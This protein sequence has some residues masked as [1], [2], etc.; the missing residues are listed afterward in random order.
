MVQRIGQVVIA[1]GLAGG[2]L[3]VAEDQEGLAPPHPL[4]GDEPLDVIPRI[5]RP[6]VRAMTLATAVGIDDVPAH[7][8]VLLDAHDPVRR[9]GTGVA[10]DWQRAREIARRRPIVL[11][12]AAPAGVS[13]TTIDPLLY[14]VRRPTI[15]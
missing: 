2:Q 15:T 10:V 1:D 8:T 12:T 4:A 3:A 7:V 6:V 13:I 14:S 5:K 9:G 11:A